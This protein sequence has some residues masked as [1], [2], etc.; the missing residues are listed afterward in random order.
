MNTK[1]DKLKLFHAFPPRR[2][3]YGGNKITIPLRN[4]VEIYTL[5]KIIAKSRIEVT[6]KCTH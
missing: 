3:S 4:L 1:T 2:L 5:V 6:S